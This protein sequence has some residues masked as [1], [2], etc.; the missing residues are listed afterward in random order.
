MSIKSSYKNKD[1]PRIEVEYEYELHLY[2]ALKAI[3][4]IANQLKLDVNRVKGILNEELKE[5]V[6]TARYGVQVTKH[7]T[8]GTPKYSKL[9]L[10]FTTT[11]MN[12]KYLE[13]IY[14]DHD[15][16]YC[17]EYKHTVHNWI[18]IQTVAQICALRRYGFDEAEKLLDVVMDEDE[19]YEEE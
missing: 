7:T 9:K 8:N 10:G 13:F 6:V 4:N 16:T 11:N 17:L 1:N 2:A 19:K 18:R 14:K 3:T 15:E 5:A 12:E